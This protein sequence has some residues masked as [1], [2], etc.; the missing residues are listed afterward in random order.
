[1]LD[2]SRMRFPS[3]LLAGSPCLRWMYLSLVGLLSISLLGCAGGGP[4]VHPVKGKVEFQGGDIRKLNEGHVEFQSMDDPKIRA[5]GT[6]QED[7]TFEMGTVY[8]VNQEAK[9]VRPGKYK[10]RVFPE[11]ED[12]R[13]IHPKFT[14]YDTSGITVEVPLKEELIIKVSR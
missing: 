9:G 12:D 6:I 13:V 10:V 14:N 3:G 2:Q 4:E 1:M 11:Y 8:N 5:A 7:G